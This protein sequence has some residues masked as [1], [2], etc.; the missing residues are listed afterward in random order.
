MV[1]RAGLQ[2]LNLNDQIVDP[3][4]GN[5]TTFFMRLLQA[6]NIVDDDLDVQVS[7]LLALEIVADDQITGGGT[8]Q[9]AIDLDPDLPKIHIG[10]AASGVAAD[11][12]GDA[13]NVPQITV[14]AEGHVTG[15]TE[16]PISG[17]GGGA[18]TEIDE[19]VTSGSAPSISFAAIAGT[20]KHLLLQV[21]GRTNNGADND[22]L[23]IR[24]NADGGNNYGH[25][26][27]GFFGSIA[28][29]ETGTGENAG[30]VGTLAGNSSQASTVGN[31]ELLIPHYAGTTWKKFVR[32]PG[33]SVGSGAPI[34]IENS[35]YWLNTAAITDI[36]ILPQGGSAFIDGTIAT[37]WGIG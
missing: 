31:V 36:L 13:T 35:F 37:L 17:G 15:V 22:N 32:G 29:G 3:A 34:N 33:G 21:Y 18:M 30:I 7:A 5:P 24:F 26:R 28:F 23:L 27:T 25:G 20:Y 2:N 12:Y 1:D 6:K 19:I 10:H 11:T 9:D 4:T 14:D 16:V 8:F